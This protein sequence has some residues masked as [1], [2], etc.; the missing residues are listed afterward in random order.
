MKYKIKHPRYFQNI[1]QYM[2]AYWLGFICADG[3]LVNN[4]S[5]VIGITLCYIDKIILKQF[6]NSIGSENQYMI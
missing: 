1:N 4:P 2:K 5:K 3:Y 6:K